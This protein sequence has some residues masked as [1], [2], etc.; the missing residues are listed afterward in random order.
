MRD[1]TF[2]ADPPYWAQST[3]AL[4]SR[5]DRSKRNTTRRL[6]N[7]PINTF[8][9]VYKHLAPPIL[10]FSAVAIVLLCQNGIVPSSHFPPVGIRPVG[11]HNPLGSTPSETPFS[12]STNIFFTSFFLLPLFISR[13][14]VMIHRVCCSFREVIY[15]S[16]FLRVFTYMLK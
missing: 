5:W 12:R 3:P 9:Q 2:F 10:T 13:W 6:I 11:T 1:N 14:G 16:F 8:Y 15:K 7:R 4:R